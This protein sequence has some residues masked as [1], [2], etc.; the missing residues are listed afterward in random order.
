MIVYWSLFL[1]CHWITG[2]CCLPWVLLSWG[3]NGGFHA[4]LPSPLKLSYSHSLYYN[5]YYVSATLTF[6]P[7]LL[8][9]LLVKASLPWL[10]PFL[11]HFSLMAWKS[12]LVPFCLQFTFVA[13]NN[14]SL[15]QLLSW[16]AHYKITLISEVVTNSMPYLR[17]LHNAS[18][19][20]LDV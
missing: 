13:C 10:F 7:L 1:H 2:V 17:G 8:G 20:S 5:M 11:G 14:K 12:C 4:H 16:R 18:L 19:R 6:P 3:A 15:V 9:C